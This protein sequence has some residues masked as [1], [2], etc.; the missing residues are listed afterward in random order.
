MD[1]NI[2]T[3]NFEPKT[4]KRR[5]DSAG[6]SMEVDTHNG[7][8]GRSKQRPPKS[9]RAKTKSFSETKDDMR[10]IPVP[11]HRY[12]PLKENWL[13]IFT[14]VVEHLQL[15]VRFNLKTRNV[16]IKTC[17]ETKDIANLQKA[18]DFVKVCIVF[19]SKEMPK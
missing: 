15:Q 16:E 3:N 1:V 7:I 9:K 5:N 8:E 4:A 12:T 6:D 10:K 14:P 19:I 11:S 18:A 2:D 17:D 13:K